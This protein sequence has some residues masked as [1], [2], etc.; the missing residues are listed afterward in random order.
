MTACA[1]GHEATKGSGV[2]LRVAVSM[3]VLA[4]LCACTRD[5]IRGL[6]LRCQTTKC[7]CIKQVVSFPEVPGGDRTEVLWRDNGDA[8]CPD[9]YVLRLEKGKK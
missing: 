2:M 3:A 7:V 1:N 5:T 8:Y 4:A 6:E 9:G